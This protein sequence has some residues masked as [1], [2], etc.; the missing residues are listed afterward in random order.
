MATTTFTDGL[1]VQLDVFGHV[2]ADRGARRFVAEE[3]FDGVGDQ[4]PVGDE[5]AS[6]VGMVGE[7]FAGPPDEAGRRLV[8][9]A[10]DHGRVQQRFVA[11]Q[12]AGRARLVLDLGPEQVA[13]EVI[14]RVVDAPVDV[15]GEH[16]A[17][18][19]GV[20]GHLHRLA[21][22]G[23]EVGVSPQSDRLLVGLGDAEQHSD[24][25]HRHL[26]PE[27]GD[28]V[29]PPRAHERI[30]AAGAE[31][32]DLGFEGGDTARREHP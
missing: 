25:P 7:H 4:R 16:L 18:E 2:P 3:L 31:L 14:R 32:T 17:A 12:T 13:H 27:V 1:V 22:L 30:E 24:H 11:G 8:A 28:E 29:E 21:S 6:L 20:L 5:L 10:G 23:P 26:G 15:L 9:G 19:A